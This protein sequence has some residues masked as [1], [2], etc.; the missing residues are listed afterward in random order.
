MIKP[1]IYRKIL[2]DIKFDF[3][4]VVYAFELHPLSIEIKQNFLL[5]IKESGAPKINEIREKLMVS[6]KRKLLG[7][8]VYSSLCSFNAS[9]PFHK[10]QEA[11]L[12]LNTEGS[13]CYNLYYEEHTQNT[14]LEKGDAIYIP[15]MLG[16]SAIPISPRISLS[17]ECE[18]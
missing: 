11:V 1:E 10:D 6:S 7:C 12:I 5:K 9:T 4:D 8:D 14:I 13:I 2:P 18:E 3:N 16:H 17:Y 15:S